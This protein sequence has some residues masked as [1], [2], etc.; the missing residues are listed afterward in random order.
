MGAWKYIRDE[1]RG[2]E[3]VPVARLASGSPATGL[4]GL[5]EMGQN[6]IVGKV[7]RNCTCE[8]LNKYCGLQ[9]VEG[10]SRKEILKVHQ[11]LDFES[12]FTI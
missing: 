7:F 6:E 3:L 9:C 2:I 5:H 11:Y 4:H 8:L 12:K 10:K 1:F